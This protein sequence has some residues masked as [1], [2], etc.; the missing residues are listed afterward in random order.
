MSIIQ[1]VACPEAISWCEGGESNP[2]AERHWILSPARLPVPPP[3]PALFSIGYHRLAETP[4]RK[5]PEMA[6]N[7][8]NFLPPPAENHQLR[9]RHIVWNILGC[10]DRLSSDTEAGMPEV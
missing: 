9:L 7:L 6:W 10:H 8:L 5:G 1:G 4:K 3:S 2:Y